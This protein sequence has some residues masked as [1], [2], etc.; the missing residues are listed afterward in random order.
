MNNARSPG[1]SAVRPI[2]PCRRQAFARIGRRI[3]SCSLPA[4]AVAALGAATLVPALAS[5]GPSMNVDGNNVNITV[6]GPNHSLKFYWAVNGSPTWHAETIAHAGTTFSAP[7]MNVDG[8]NVNIT[9]AGHDDSLKF[10]WAVNGTPTWHPEQVA[11]PG[12][13]S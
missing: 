3:A 10:Y 2:L 7:A 5:T 6:Q 8:N 4:V 11:R 9:V 12:S 13:V 1:I